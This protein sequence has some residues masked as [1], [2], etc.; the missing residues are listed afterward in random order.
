MSGW[1]PNQT[2]KHSID[3]IAKSCLA[4]GLLSGMLVVAGPLV[5]ANP[6]TEKGAEKS[7]EK[8][9]GIDDRSPLPPAIGPG[10]FDIDKLQIPNPK[11]AIFVG[12]MDG[13]GNTVPG[14][15]IIDFEEIASEKKNAD[16]Y[17]AWHEVVQQAKSFPT[18][19]LEE[20]ARRDLTRDDLIGL[21]PHPRVYRLSLIRFEGKIA[22][23][24]RL[25]ATKSLQE[26]GT[27]E[28][29]EAQLVAYDEPP[30]DSVSIVFTE[31][32]EALAEVA[33]KPAEQWLDV[34]VDAI[35]AGYFFKVKQDPHRTDK[36]PVLI[37]KSVTVL[38]EQPSSANSPNNE[39]AKNKN[40]LTALDKNLQVFKSIKDDARI[41]KGDEN[42]QEAVA[43]NRV[44]LHARRYS[45]EELESN[46]RRD[47]KFADLF[48]SVRNDYKLQ[49][50]RFEGRLLMLRKMEP[51]QKLRAAGLNAAY[52]GWLVPQDEP[53]GN[54]ICI[55]F[56]DLPEGIE[57]GRVN[58]WV[59]FAGYS[60]KLMRYES[61]E[62]DKDDPNKNVTKRAPL[63]LG[64]A[65][66][67]QPD[68][69]TPSTI[70]WTAFVQVV[71]AGVIGLIGIAACLAW[72]FRRGDSRAK[73]EIVNHR[74][75]NPFGE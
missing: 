38:K 60:F 12:L 70:T 35:G 53:R 71:L 40:N 44:L 46:A 25:A 13:K 23:V 18:T 20:Y 4:G 11:R 73:Q 10:Q 26:S 24:R 49:L 57:F 55:V 34:N 22:R 21:G 2:S 16:E 19:V 37:G 8:V 58:R 31:L 9:S 66:T 47:L 54:P 14:T 69:D 15:G 41:P 51:S 59:S 43:W 64:R 3:I 7:S 5:M 63:L 62:R 68:P 75:K 74:S 27:T 56:T 67:Y 50:V 33:K 17:W 65:I 29:Y 48:E 39:N 52:E 72:W 30:T 32:P 6:P 28:V 61:G 36:V 1:T 42:W 45:P